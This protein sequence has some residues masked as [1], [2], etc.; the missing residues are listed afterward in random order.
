MVTAE[1]AFNITNQMYHL[2]NI[3]ETQ[4][5][6]DLLVKFAELYPLDME[7]VVIHAYR[8]WLEACGHKQG[9]ALAFL[10]TMPEARQ[11]DQE[12]YQKYVKRLPGNDVIDRAMRLSLNDMMKYFS[13]EQINSLHQ[14]IL[15]ER[16]VETPDTYYGLCR[17]G[18]ATMSLDGISAWRRYIGTDTST[19]FHE[20]LNQALYELA[21]SL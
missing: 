2:M 3:E 10:R 21:Q 8:E 17:L 12:L 20:K 11:Y 6:T 15:I 5:F 9:M 14:R 19:Y 13:I 18:T 1:H 4:L 7:S 16:R